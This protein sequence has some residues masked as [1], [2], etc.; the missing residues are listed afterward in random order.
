MFP[1]VEDNTSIL[2]ERI[3]QLEQE[4][5]ELKG[6]IQQAETEIRLK[7]QKMVNLQNDTDEARKQYKE[8]LNQVVELKLS[9]TSIKEKSA[10]IQ[11]DLQKK[12][13]ELQSEASELRTKIQEKD[14][15]SQKIQVDALKEHEQLVFYQMIIQNMGKMITPESPSNDASQILKSLEQILAPKPMSTKE[16]QA[17]M[18]YRNIA[19]IANIPNEKPKPAPA[20]VVAKPIQEIV[21]DA[22]YSP[23]EKPKSRQSKHG[24]YNNERDGSSRRNFDDISDRSESSHHRRRKADDDRSEPSRRSDRFKF[25]KID[26][27]IGTD[28]PLDR[29]IEMHEKIRDQEKNSFRRTHLK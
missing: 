15:A 9:N 3:R 22:S 10:K 27:D 23:I 13:L 5:S 6:R 4:N 17:T 28:I 8:L 12:I 29:F 14:S 25:D 18:S 2:N 1:S 7:C 20:A 26:S 19:T 21:S 24:R 16:V 11:N